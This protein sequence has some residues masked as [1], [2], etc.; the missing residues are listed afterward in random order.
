MSKMFLAGVRAKSNA[1]Y[2]CQECGSTELIQAHHEIPGDDNTLIVLCAGCHSKRHPNVP[3]ALFFS[4]RGIQPYWHNKSA[5][6]IARELLVHPRTVVRA[7]RRLRISRGNLSLL[8]EELLKKEIGQG[9]PPGA[10][11]RC[12]QCSY[13]WHVRRPYP[14]QCRGCGGLG[15]ISVFV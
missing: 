14:V 4:P 3:L 2:R 8:G 13:S 7:A 10:Y 5:S 15:G 12:N 1:H 11:A 9:L 6:S